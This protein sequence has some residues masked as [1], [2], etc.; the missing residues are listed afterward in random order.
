ML[1]DR[2]KEV[3]LYRNLTQKELAER[4]GLAT[5]TIQGYEANKFKPK[6]KTLE[7]IANALDIPLSYFFSSSNPNE[8]ENGSK[9]TT[10]ANAFDVMVTAKTENVPPEY[11]TGDTNIS[12]LDE[13]ALRNFS[14][15]VSEENISR[16]LSAYDYSIE[17]IEGM[18]KFIGHLFLNI[19]TYIWEGK[20][21]IKYKEFDSIYLFGEIINYFFTV[22]TKT[23]LIRQ[24][25]KVIDDYSIKIETAKEYQKELVKE[26]LE[27]LQPLLNMWIENYF[28]RERQLPK[29]LNE[30]KDYREKKEE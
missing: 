3:R 18:R 2:L 24:K 28:K 21:A 10:L 16:W 30:V 13:Y 17:E 7:K 1:G 8:F 20:G 22:A 19:Q 4:V 23:D 25:L 5:I 27:H 15:I 14:K 12:D 11:L 9:T 6:L 26:S 29:Y